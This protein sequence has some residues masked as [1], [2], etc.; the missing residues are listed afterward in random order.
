MIENIFCK[1]LTLPFS[2]DSWNVKE[3]QKISAR[4]DEK[5]FSSHV[6][7]KEFLDWLTYLGVFVQDC[8][9]FNAAPLVR[10]RP[11]KDISYISEIQKKHTD[12][13]KINI[14]FN[15]VNSKMIWYRL[16]ENESP[17]ISKN[18]VGEKLYVYPDNIIDQIYE[19]ETDGPAIL[20][21][22]M[23]IH[24]LHNGNSHRLCLSMPL[25]NVNSGKRITWNEAE[26]I[27]KDYLI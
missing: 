6:L 27:F 20:I 11:H 26:E 16:K 14:I 2:F 12:C 19:A 13:V 21:N 24:T 17:L 8:R 5:P 23:E 18:T 25:F 1:K 7:D 15:S 22:G 9:V 3:F 4:I 10:Y